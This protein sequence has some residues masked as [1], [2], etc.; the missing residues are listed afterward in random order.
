M[1]N[2]TDRNRRGS[3]LLITLGVLSMALVMGMCFAFSARTSLQ[4]A[5]VSSDQTKA[6]L[7]AE[8]GLARVMAIL[9]DLW[10]GTTNKSYMAHD[11]TTDA[12]HPFKFE[13][14]A[15]LNVMFSVG[16]SDEVGA[17]ASELTD[18]GMADNLREINSVS[19]TTDKNYNFQ[20]ITRSDGETVGRIGFIVIDDTDKLDVNQMLTLRTGGDNAPY[21]KKGDSAF[22]KTFAAPFKS[23]GSLQ[24]YVDGTDY[25]FRVTRSDNAQIN[26]D[27]ENAQTISLG[28][29]LREVWFDGRKNYYDSLPG[30]LLDSPTLKI[31]FSS[32]RHLNNAVASFQ[33]SSDYLR[34]TFFSGLE[35]EVYNDSGTVRRRFDLTG[36]EWGNTVDYG[37]DNPIDSSLSPISK[38]DL[39]I[40]L[41]NATERPVV[42]SNKVYPGQGSFGIPCIKDNR[43]LAANIVDFCDEDDAAT[44]DPAYNCLNPTADPEFCGNEA[45][46]YINEVAAT[47]TAYKYNTFDDSSTDPPNT[48]KQHRYKYVLEYQ[49]FLE[50]LNI[51]PNR[52]KV[53]I[54]DGTKRDFKVL[55]RLYG[56]LK[57]TNGTE[58]HGIQLIGSVEDTGNPGLY[59]EGHFNDGLFTFKEST[60][61]VKIFSE[62]DFATPDNYKDD[63]TGASTVSSAKEAIE[64]FDTGDIPYTTN[65]ITITANITKMAVV[66][67]IDGASGDTDRFEADKDIVLDTAWFDTPQEVIFSFPVEYGAGDAPKEYIM[68]RPRAIGWQVADPRVNHRKDSWSVEVSAEGTNESAFTLGAVNKPFTDNVGASGNDVENAASL[69]FTH[70]TVDD[71]AHTFSTAFLP[72]RPFETLWELGCIHTGEPFKTIPLLDETSDYRKIV[73]EVKIGPIKE[74]RDKYNLNASR[75]E[76]FFEL[77]KNIDVSKSYWDDYCD[78]EST[79]NGP[80]VNDSDGAAADKFTIADFPDTWHDAF[81]GV[82]NRSEFIPLFK[83]IMN[84]KDSTY[85]TTWTKREQEALYGRTIGL[86]SARY[87]RYTIL[88]TG[89]SLKQINIPTGLDWDDIKKGV[90]NPLTWNGQHFS[91]L[92]RQRI[93]AHVIQ[94]TWNNTFEFSQLTY[95]EEE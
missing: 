68:G 51:Y 36:L 14:Q 45:V 3:A 22:E 34:Y 13:Q 16:A 41:S 30:N 10:D 72:N 18:G 32:Y 74:R 43:Q 80:E 73:D 5:Q 64:L 25:L 55:V 46:P 29:T 8:S 49:T 4:A 57:W 66:A 23:D 27:E 6:R 84:K 52:L 24:T 35:Q 91:S 50:M 77:I 61:G 92:G 26:N 58:E 93:L 11:D 83:E 95:L 54:P 21:I 40:H 81:A 37:W 67:F 65:P 60:D 86:L 85:A 63:D 76:T 1:K 44:I 53:T 20:A 88:V 12:G 17:L 89:E 71:D 15:D 62:T 28:N 33:N 56:T 87:A 59:T 47:F 78:S 9:K 31:P 75:K 38:A 79:Y 69:S 90:L 19:W 70:A 7:I 42:D 94:D 82:Q 39:V 2:K 48:P